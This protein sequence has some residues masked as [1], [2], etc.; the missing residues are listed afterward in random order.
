MNDLNTWGLFFE[1]LCVRDLRVFCSRMDGNVYHYPDKTGLECD[2][3]AHLRNGDYG[4]IENQ[5][6]W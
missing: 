6:W 2:T 1:T 5:N 4:L 3:V